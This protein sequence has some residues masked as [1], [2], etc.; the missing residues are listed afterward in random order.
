MIR[1]GHEAEIA[2]APIELGP[3]LER[4]LGWSAINSGTPNLAGLATMAEVLAVAFARLPGELELLDPAPGHGVSAT[5][6]S[7][8][9]DAGKH[10]VLRVRPDAERRVLLTGHMD[11]VYGPEDA[12]QTCEWLDERRLRGPGVLDMKSGLAVMLAGLEAFE[13]SGPS[14]GY[15]V[16]INSDE[17]TGSASSASIIAD[18]ARGKL[19]ALTYEPT[20][21]GGF[22]ARAR[23]GSGNYSAVVRGRAAHAGRNPEDGRNALVAAS[24][25]ALRLSRERRPDFS[26]NPAKID[27]G[28][29]NN[30]VPPLAVLRFNIRPRAAEDS[31][32]AAD[33]VARLS[34]EFLRITTWRSMS[35]EAWAGPRSRS[36]QLPKPCLRWSRMLPRR[37]ATESSGAIPVASATAT[38]SLPAASP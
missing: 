37:S 9:I 15:D 31:A 23:P 20:M 11:T 17:E 1:M 30:V 33:L 22:V 28:G 21:P 34:A 18:L 10:L 38:T 29:P 16:L 3:M 27:G 36:E 7:V 26:I 2:I 6:E 13:Q 8:P 19:A 24:D 12:F 14:L 32:E 4:V 25:L 35:T 5:G